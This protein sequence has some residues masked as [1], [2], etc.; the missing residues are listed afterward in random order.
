MCLSFEADALRP[1]LRQLAGSTPKLPGVPTS[2]LPAASPPD[3]SP[4]WVGFLIL[5]AVGIVV[6]LVIKKLRPRLREQ[7]YRAWEE[8]GLLP[9]QLDR[10]RD[11]DAPRDP[12]PRHDPGRGGPR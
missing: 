4:G 1:T 6:F 5:L 7:R 8:A 10:D 12:D 9:E 3:S 11:P 2:T